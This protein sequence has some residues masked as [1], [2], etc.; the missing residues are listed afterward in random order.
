MVKK[1]KKPVDN[2]SARLIFDHITVPIA[3]TLVKTEVSPN[4]VT[5][6]SLLLAL[7]AALFFLSPN[8]N[9]LIIG[10]IIYFFLLY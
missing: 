2:W 6:A 5:F 4:K 1:F 8:Y 3:K 9:Y 10:V 7:I